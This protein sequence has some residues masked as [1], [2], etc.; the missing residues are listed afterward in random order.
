MR[1]SS[2]EMSVNHS[3]K[4]APKRRHRIRLGRA[5][6]RDF[7]PLLAINPRLALVVR[8]ERRRLGADRLWEAHDT[9]S[10]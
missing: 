1:E 2:V 6:E 9:I 3:A 8:V 10:H 7:V 4:R 5:E